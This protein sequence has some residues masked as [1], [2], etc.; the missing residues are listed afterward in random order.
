MAKL[1]D[2]HRQD[3]PPSRRCAR[4]WTSRTWA[5][6][7]TDGA[8]FKDTLAKDNAYFKSLITKLNIKP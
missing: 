5:T 3:Q 1:R 4:R 7:Y 6:S 8:A 2:D